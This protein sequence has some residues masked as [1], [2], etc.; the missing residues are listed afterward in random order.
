MLGRQM[1]RQRVPRCAAPHLKSAAAAA[2]ALVERAEPAAEHVLAGIG[3]LLLMLPAF[4]P[5]L[6]EFKGYVFK[7]SGGQDKQGFPMKQGVLTNGRVFLLM[8][9]GA[10]HTTAASGISLARQC[11]ERVLNPQGHSNNIC[12]EA[13]A[14]LRVHRRRMLPGLRPPQGRAPPE[15]CARLHR[16]R[17]PVRAEP[18]HRPQG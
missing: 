14:A 16:Q 11:E 5:T 3:P 1:P 2:A 12:T 7:I 17:R 15:G 9:P 6:Q 8:K 18:G 13:F 4:L 10:W